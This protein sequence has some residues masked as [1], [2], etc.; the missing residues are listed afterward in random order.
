MVIV[1][2]LAAREPGQEAPVGRGVVEVP[3]AAA[4]TQ[5]VDE[6]RDDEHVQNG[7]QESRNEAGPE[8]DQRTEQAQPESEAEDAVGEEHPIEPIR[9]EVR[10]K[11]LDGLLVAPL[12]HVV[13]AVEQWDTPEAQEPGLCGSPSRSVKVW[14]LR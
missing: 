14:C 10:G 7:M 8:A 2:T 1:Q 12:A 9:P 6:G 4:V 11:H 3:G 5:C 13:G